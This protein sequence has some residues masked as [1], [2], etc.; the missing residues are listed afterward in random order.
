MHGTERMSLSVCSFAFLKR[1]EK[2]LGLRVTVFKGCL[3]VFLKK[4]NLLYL[5]MMQK[6][7]FCVRGHKGRWGGSNTILPHCHRNIH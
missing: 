4:N 1:K 3:V 7:Y 6:L 2:Q 5:E